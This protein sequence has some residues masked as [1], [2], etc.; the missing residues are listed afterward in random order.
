MDDK[1]EQILP[2][3]RRDST[4]IP[5]PLFFHSAALVD[6]KDMYIFGGWRLTPQSKSG[7]GSF[8]TY[9]RALYKFDLESREWDCVTVFPSEFSVHKVADPR[10]RVASHTSADW[11]NT[12]PLTLYNGDQFFFTPAHPFPRIGTV[13]ISYMH[14]LFLFGGW[15]NRE[16]NDLWMFSPESRRWTC[17]PT[18]GVVPS[19]RFEI[20]LVSSSLSFSH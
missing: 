13:M 12:P 3:N 19:P 1:W 17:C 14:K 7:E 5:P 6:D 10:I 4:N 11:L 18:K 16:L 15:A 20:S 8:I 2:S 9:N